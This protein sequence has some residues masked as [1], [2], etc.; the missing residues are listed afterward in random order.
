MKEVQYKVSD[1]HCGGC[2]NA[3]SNVLRKNEA[4]DSVDIDIAEKLV[5]VVFND[6]EVDEQTLESQLDRI[7]Y[8]PELVSNK[9][10]A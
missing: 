3:I 6:Q 8:H 2:A 5:K 7:G 1:I 4:V 9:D 10:L